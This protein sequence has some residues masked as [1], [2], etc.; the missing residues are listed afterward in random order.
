MNKKSGSVKNTGEGGYYSRLT[1]FRRA[2]PI[3]LAAVAVFIAVCYIAGD[4]GLLGKGLNAGLLG[5][6]S[7]GAYA[8]PV[9]IILHA[10]FYAE[11][12]AKSRVLSRT[13]FSV[14]T[15]ILISSV[16]YAV[17]FWNQDP[18][19][20]P[21]Q[22]FLAADCG[23]FLGS[24][25]AYALVHALGQVG[26]IIFAAAL[27]S[28]YVAFFFTS[29][30]RAIV[31][32]VG[33]IASG[34]KELIGGT[35][36]RAK[37]A[38]AQAKAL[39]NEAKNNKKARLS[40][41]DAK[42]SEA[43]LDDSFFA[44][45]NGMSELRITE[46]N[47]HEQR[48]AET[49]EQNP[50]LQSEVFHKSAVR[51]DA[52]PA[53][54]S[55]GAHTA[56]YDSPR[57]GRKFNM[58]FARG[59]DLRDDAREPSNASFVYED[60]GAST[61]FSD[62][63]SPFERPS[64]EPTGTASER[65]GFGLDES[66]D[67]VFTPEF[68]PYSSAINM[69]AA[70]GATASRTASR[71]QGF[72]S[73]EEPVNLPTEEEVAE[74]RRKEAAEREA[75]RRREA[76]ERS[77]REA[78]ERYRKEQEAA[79]AARTANQS[80]ESVPSPARPEPAVSEPVT[81]EPAR[82]NGVK[83]V[84][85]NVEHEP[86]VI[87]V[88]S[89]DGG[90]SRTYGKPERISDNV[91]EV[92]AAVAEAVARSNPAYARSANE[93]IRTTVTESRVSAAEP[94]ES[95][96]S[97][98]EPTVNEPTTDHI[99]DEPVPAAE[100]A[101]SE[102]YGGDFRPYEA[103]TSEPAA[104]SAPAA[105]VLRTERDMLS[106]SHSV[107]SA[108]RD[109][110]YTVID[111]NMSEVTEQTDAA[112]ASDIT[113]EGTTFIFDTEEEPT[114]PVAPERTADDLEIFG[115]EDLEDEEL[116]EDE[117][118]EPEDEDESEAPAEIPPEEQN[119]DV[120]RQRAMFPFLDE[121]PSPATKPENDP[122][123][124]EP[125]VQ[126]EPEDEDEPPFDEPVQPKNTEPA[127]V[128]KVTEPAPAPAK[129]ESKKPDYSNYQF[130]PLELLGLN[131][132]AADENAQAEVQENADKLI[133]TLASFNVT[134][135]I[136]GVDRGPR[137][138]RYEVVPA[139]GVKVS[140]IMSL[141]DDIALNL[142]AGA[143]R[144]EAPIPGKSAVGVEIPNKKSSTVRL[145]ELIET[146][147]F[148]NEKSRTCVCMGK[149]VAGQPVFADIAKM[150]HALIA[151]ATGMGKS[152]CINSLMISMLY[153]ARPD[154]VKFIMIDPKQVEFTMYNGIPHLLVP[155]VTDVHQAAGTLMWAV[156]EMERRY[157]LLQQAAARNIENYN[158]KV[159]EKPHLGEPLHR[160]V[161]VIDE[162]AELIMQAKNPVESLVIRIAQKARA[163]G[164]HLIIG[165]QK[166]VKEV[167]TG[168]IKSNI[169]SKFSC[170]VASNR[171]SILIFD[172]SGAEKLL[173]KGDMLVAFA[174][175]LQPLRVQCAFVADE[176][177]E[178]VMD[179][180]KENAGGAEYD[181]SVMEEIRRAADR[182]QN[183]GKGGGAD[184]DDDGE[185]ESGEGY[186]NDKQF[187]DAVDVAISSRKISTSLIQ[188]RIS[189]GYGKAAKFIDIMEDMGIVGPSNGQ[190]PREVL[191]SEDEWR[192]KL[193][194][195]MID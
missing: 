146:E 98:A 2:V 58:D 87:K 97:A 195:T 154:E 55:A 152:V 169:P 4:T 14:I 30:K 180:L 48:S 139:K 96:V 123:P 38:R 56:F 32:A 39:K 71:A 182:C 135:S 156:E 45:D 6:F 112:S 66:A 140:S 134:A 18:A 172:Q 164:I 100:P 26:L 102:S 73:Y 75:T 105:E 133:D 9:L 65:R 42:K 131:A 132:K 128:K 28:V 94:T 179:F 59:S 35:A 130:P 1:G 151:G 80:T 113:D 82:D 99:I 157:T 174:N 34:V 115:D 104:E 176:E 89:F 170:K 43:L 54:S 22:H 155:I 129:Q 161:I 50:T 63:P 167:I 46:L 158:A 47:I 166:P 49:A 165:T 111:D 37:E 88:P 64:N 107:A 68:D 17:I 187:L 51:A 16:E 70:Q 29:G 57:S 52:E 171:D 124:A 108:L 185:R 173:D 7:Y 106:P 25:V 72:N 21:G 143:I 19:F 142:A 150:P 27:F 23:G 40:R 188:R 126:N 194:R 121:S 76:F 181:E 190:R 93:S 91:E 67:A 120:I 183:N 137:I 60:D 90:V 114:A 186:L 12:Y 8:I 118:L 177:V 5:L 61:V 168:L 13:I 122:A 69:K 74:I 101:V 10:I 11:D 127:P 136:K 125:V 15:V 44:V 103:P 141:Q 20:T 77:K 144:M 116:D 92:A 191:I 178:A 83:T 148:R 3:I 24:T 53:A 189:I 193:A 79:T 78:Q 109:S 31:G 147:D 62:E 95:R 162:F 159:A 138:T 184:D 175:S 149:D 33:G 192:E 117:Y 160:I 153:K 163:A 81:S 84:E 145:R 85:F 41:E 119:P 86:T 110:A 36:K